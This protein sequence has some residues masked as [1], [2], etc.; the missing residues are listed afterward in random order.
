[1]LSRSSRYHPATSLVLALLFIFGLPFLCVAAEV[2]I[3]DAWG[4]NVTVPENVTRVICSGPGCLRYLTYLQAQELAVGVDSIET[5]R[6]PGPFD[7]RPYS[8]AHPELGDKPLFGEFRGHD[9]PEL[10]VSL[11]PAPQVIFKTFG[12][13]G[14]DP[15]ELQRKT[16]IPVVV[17]NYGHLATGREDIE[18]S[19]LLMGRILDREQRAKEVLRFLDDTIDD[20]QVRTSNVPEDQ[21]P[22]CYVGGVA[23]KGPHGV[24]STEPFYP[25]FAF[26]NARNVAIGPEDKQFQQTVF[27]KEALITADPDFL[28]VDLS[29]IR[30]GT[31]A[32]SLYQLRNQAC[33]QIL[34]AV[35]EGRIY[36]VLPYNWYSQNYGSILADAY[37]VGKVLY[38]QRFE[39]IDP[40][41]KADGIYSFLVGRPVFREMYEA[42][43]NMAFTRIDL[44]VTEQK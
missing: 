23:S 44:A 26:V 18:N 22:S 20:L 35:R 12:N 42:F 33:Y 31:G 38:P 7:A 29:T 13:M 36:G 19:L 14:H 28:F 39:D 16:G 9:N 21:R 24:T 40:A 5:G 41:E 34:S 25:P 43:G 2:Q 17:L 1:M 8:I 3:T 30:S 15:G 11:H 10:I 32:G 6:Q 37:F 27:S 4:R